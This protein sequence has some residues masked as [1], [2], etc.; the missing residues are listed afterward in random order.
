MEQ[1]AHGRAAG[2][3]T[4]DPS[5]LQ[6]WLC[7]CLAAPLLLIDN[8]LSLPKV[9]L[10]YRRNAELN[11]KQGRKKTGKSEQKKKNEAGNEKTTS[12][13]PYFLEFDQI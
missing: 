9:A 2:S 11:Y 4:W 12:T 3:G 7:C 10:C 13:T 1:R 5:S 8:S 6:S